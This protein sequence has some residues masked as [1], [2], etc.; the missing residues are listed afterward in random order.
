MPAREST[1][2]LPA[3]PRSAGLSAAE[4]RRIALRAQGFGSTRLTGACGARALM[5]VF[6]RI[7]LVQIDSVNVLV[8]SHYF[9]LFSRLGAYD[10]KLLERLVW[11]KR[12]RKLFEYWGHEA[13]L[14]PLTMYPLFRWR[15]AR[16]ARGEG[17]WGRVA[18]IAREKPGFV[19]AILREVEQRGPLASGDIA[20]H[21]STGG[22]WWGWSEVK[23]ALEY[24]FWSGAVTTARRRNFERLYDLPERVFAPAILAAPTPD[25]ASAKR[26]LMR[27]AARALGIATRLDLRDY[28]RLET[29]AN[30]RIDELVEHGDLVPVRVEGWKQQAYLARDAIV[31]RRIDARA[32]LSP[33]DS[34]VWERSRD[35]RVFDFDYRIEIYTP[36]P[37]RVHG[38]Y[39]L[40]FLYGDRF[41]ARVDVKA[42]RDTGVLDAI[43]V[44]YED[45]QPALE[46]RDELRVELEA[47]AGWLGLTRVK[48]GRTTRTIPGAGV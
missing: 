11:E 18:A 13:S 5:S 45:A 6:E 2:A 35:R 44:H 23:V 28:F 33:F 39:V 27:I 41:A 12:G 48:I 38:Y 9:P 37:K 4:A 1:L 30:E 42:R 34:L 21:R 25:E 36:A 19:K 47:L 22:G 24:L 15:M 31:P 10:V 3:A 17:T 26:E 40:P 43:A 20:E 29:D 8:R 32:L 46:L 14:I 7:G 16:A